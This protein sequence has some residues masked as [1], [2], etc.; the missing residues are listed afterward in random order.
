MLAPEHSISI[1]EQ[2]AHCS[3]HIALAVI[4]LSSCSGFVVFTVQSSIS[5]P[6]FTV[7]PIWNVKHK[8]QKFLKYYNCNLLFHVLLTVFFF[9]QLYHS[10][11]KNNGTISSVKPDFRFG[12]K[13]EIVCYNVT[14]KSYIFLKKYFKGHSK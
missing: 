2:T 8:N 12:L 9:K 3:G 13:P 7:K 11:I 14:Q 1:E 6:I 10:N 4:T 5:S